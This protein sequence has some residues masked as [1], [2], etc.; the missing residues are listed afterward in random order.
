M[1]E[2]QHEWKSRRRGHEICDSRHGGSP[3]KRVNSWLCR[4]LGLWTCALRSHI[5]LQDERNRRILHR[6]VPIAL[7]LRARG[8]RHGLL[9]WNWRRKIIAAEACPC[10]KS[11]PCVL[12]MQTAE[13]GPL[14]L[15]KI[16]SA[17]AWQHEKESAHLPSRRLPCSTCSLRLSSTGSS[18]GAGLRSRTCICAISSISR[19]GKLRSV[20]DCSALIEHSLS[21]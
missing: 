10:R 5:I 6:D 15:P 9:P 19:C 16:P 18:R 4:Q 13:N 8:S 20:A 17:Q 3:S 1:H 11:N 2:A 7:C 14:S 12:V 21:G